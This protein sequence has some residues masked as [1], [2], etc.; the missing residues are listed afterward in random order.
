M[1]IGFDAIELHMA[2]G[3]LL[4]GFLSPIS[5]QRN[6]DWGGALEGR[7]RF[8]LEVAR[9]VRDVVP[10]GTP[11]G[12]RLTGTDWLDGGLTVT[13]AVELAKRAERSRA[14]LRRRFVRRR[15]Q[16]SG[17]ASR[18]NPATMFRWRARSGA[19]RAFPRGSSA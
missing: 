8:P 19:R 11:L 2:H 12:A 7:M 6:D 18:P 4:H 10:R 14:R 9:D 16:G 1:R 15:E 17:A 5:N 3:Y 13:D